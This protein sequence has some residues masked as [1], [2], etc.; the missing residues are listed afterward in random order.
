MYCAV[1]YVYAKKLLDWKFHWLVDVLILFAWVSAFGVANELLE[2][3]LA[4]S[5]L[6][7]I[8]T[9]DTS[10]DLLANTTGAYLAYVVMSLVAAI[11]VQPSLVKR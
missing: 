3:A 9:S 11:C 10:W 4:K 7:L 8:D 1:L 2:F 6:M 5:H